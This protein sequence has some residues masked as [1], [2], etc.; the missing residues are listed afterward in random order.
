MKSFVNIQ[1][2]PDIILA[3][4]FFALW[5]NIACQTAP[6]EGVIVQEG[7]AT[8]EVRLETAIDSTGRLACYR[9]DSLVSEWALPYPCFQFQH[10]DVNGDGVI[11]LAVGVMKPTRFDAQVRKRLFLYQI[12]HGKIIPL[13]LG[14]SLAHSLYDFR[15]IEEKD[16]GARIRA[17]EWKHAPAPNYMVV[18]YRYEGFGPGFLRYLAEDI[19]LQQAKALLKD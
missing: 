19:T 8:Y 13:W 18:E 11:D 16:D 1:K 4:S 12:R 3:A 2:L 17:V 14:S 15:I 10:G 7:Q 5:G 9:H 6:A